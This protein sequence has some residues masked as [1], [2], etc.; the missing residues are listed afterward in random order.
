VGHTEPVSIPTGAVSRTARLASLPA[1]SGALGLE[2]LWRRR[3]LHQDA[4]AVESDLRRRSTERTRR[5]LGGLKGGALKTGQLL[6]TVEMLFP[7]DPEGSWRQA[8]TDLQES[9]PPLPF[10][11]IRPLLV[12]GLGP[13]WRGFVCEIDE[14]ATAAA[15]IGQVHRGVWH[16]GRSIAIKVQYPGVREAITADLRALAWSTRAMSVVARGVSMPPLV[17]EI[18]TRLVEE[19]DYVHEG[20]VQQA[21]ARAFADDDEVVVPAVLHAASRVLVTEWI[22]GTPLARLGDDEATQPMRDAIGERYQRFLLSGPSRTGYLHTDPHPGNFRRLDDGRLGVMDFGSSL[23]LPQGMP[24]A[25]GRLM[26]VMQQS[27]EEAVLAGLRAEGFVKPGRTVDAAKLVDYLAPFSEPAK[28]ERFTFTRDWLRTE[29]ARVNDPRNP[30]F[31]VAL[32]LDIPAE[33]LF[34]HRVWL[35]VIGVLSQL[36]AT[37]PVRP[38]LERWLPGFT[39]DD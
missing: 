22:D 11:E 28:H 21:F 9:N 4:A 26:R 17:G 25:F 34:T 37:V 8:L 20:H 3:V 19:L 29:F 6:S 39:Q 27:D 14:V 33:L 38:E 16:D 30:E 13:D 18:R 15:S 5:V 35:G 32:Q 2:G 31:A 1:Y 12:E 7:P 23:A 10:D 36:G 24:S